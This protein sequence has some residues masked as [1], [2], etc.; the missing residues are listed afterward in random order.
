MKR[1]ISLISY[2]AVSMVGMILAFQPF[3]LS[4]HTAKRS[5]R[6]RLQVLYTFKTVK[7]GFFPEGKLIQDASG[8]LYGTAAMGGDG[9]CATNESLGCGLIFKLDKTGK[10][11]DLH[12]FNGKD[13][14]VPNGGLV[15]D[16]AGNLYGTTNFGGTGSCFDPAAGGCGT[17][18]KLDKS[19]KETVLHDFTG[20]ADGGYPLAGLIR[21]A[22]GN[23]YG[24]TSGC[25]RCGDTAGKVFKLD[26]TGHETVLHSFAGGQ[27]GAAP[28]AE[29]LRDAAGNLYGTTSYGGKFNG[30]T[31]F[32]LDTTGKET[33]LYRFTGGADGGAPHAGLIQDA[34]GNLY[35]TTYYGG[36]LNCNVLNPPGCGVV[37]KLSMN[38]HET[39][40][41]R[42]TGAKDGSFPPDGLVGDGKGTLYGTT[43]LGGD[44]NC[45]DQGLPGC[46]VVFKMDTTGHETVLHSF[47]GGADG[48]SP[49][50][51]SLLR[52]ASGNLY[53]TNVAG[54]VF[55]LTP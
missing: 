10:K 14:S 41:H 24:T 50:F 23:L 4:Q 32:K 15:R 53:G 52:D 9:N 36:D 22:A 43:Y 21:D 20:N 33:V 19:G 25:S 13:G 27:D 34:A 28:Q 31:V 51:G 35:G 47:T 46:G 3:A 2:T 26:A 49:F 48:L 37:F 39:V 55:K 1:S 42:F 11:T 44:P 18:F 30:G 17:V 40:L 12:D 38:G 16:A 5:P 8:T 6:A 7:D 29:L 45:S 54:V